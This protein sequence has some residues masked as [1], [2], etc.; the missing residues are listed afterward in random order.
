MRN[1]YQ[2][3]ILRGIAALLVVLFHAKPFIEY[4]TPNYSYLFNGGSYLG[5]SLF[6]ILSG[7]VIS[8][9]TQNNSKIYIFLIQ[10]FFRVYIPLVVAIVI[11]AYMH[12]KIFSIYSLLYL[13]PDV[14]GAAP[15]YGYGIYFITWTLVY[16]LLFY[17]L[18]AVSMFISSKNRLEIVIGIIL[19]NTILLQVILTGQ[20]SFNVNISQ[21]KY[22]I[23]IFKQLFSFIINPINLLFL[24]GVL[25]YK[26]RKLIEKLSERKINKI[27]LLSITIFVMLGF[28]YIQGHG[29]F[30]M[31]L[32]SVITFYYFLLWHYKSKENQ[33]T[34]IQRIFIYLG[35]V[36][37]SLYLM[38]YI[39]IDLRIYYLKLLGN[40]ISIH[41]LHTLIVFF[42]I[43]VVTIFFYYLVDRPLHKIGKI[44]S[45]KLKVIN[46]E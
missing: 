17:I 6:F 39:A 25:F 20:L 19:I 35:T 30:Q 9:S 45:K 18:F 12:S 38:H 41:E 2:L 36:S 5:V 34:I 11:Y 32:F 26:Y 42:A 27:E 15:Y 28:F 46:N 14:T 16:E 24:I 3:D 37:Y 33:I 10:R 8:L 4:I 31:G 1:I 43:I 7:F 21:I 44:V 40:Y 29:I 23:P 13:I 22:D